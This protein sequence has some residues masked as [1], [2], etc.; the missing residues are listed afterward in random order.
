MVAKRHAKA[1][2]FSFVRR[3]L[4]MLGLP[5]PDGR[6]HEAKRLAGVIDYEGT[7]R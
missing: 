5:S 2:R 6:V 4:A 1:C 7:A 3:H